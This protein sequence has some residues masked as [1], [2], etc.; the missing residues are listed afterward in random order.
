MKKRIFITALLSVI[1]TAV[2]VAQSD[3]LN[4]VETG[5]ATHEMDSNDLVAGHSLLPIGQAVTVTS[6]ESGARVTVTITE[7][8]PQTSSRIIDLSAGAAVALAIF[9]ETSQVTVE[10]ELKRAAPEAPAAPAAAP[11]AATTA[12]AVADTGPV[13]YTAP[14]PRPEPILTSEIEPIVPPWETGPFTPWP[15]Q[16]NDPLLP[17]L[18]HPWISGIERPK[19]TGPAQIPTPPPRTVPPPRA[20][21][22][23]R[24]TQ[25]SVNVIPRM[26]DPRDNTLYRVQ[27]GAFKT[28]LN[29]QEVFDRLL[30]AGF[31]PAFEVGGGL[32]RVLIPWMRG[33]EIQALGERL[34][35]AGFRE[36]W[37]REES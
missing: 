1:L 7:R 24:D 22:P 5:T 2:C 32:T 31:S 14:P 17:E 10:A 12:P 19:I 20:V 6:L 33:Y 15:V 34:Y 26:P 16:P 25:P 3:P 37:L 4:F 8:I 30:N 36:V 28:R 29:A 21:Q 18:V 9:K 27:I 13:P 11:K 35:R 23:P